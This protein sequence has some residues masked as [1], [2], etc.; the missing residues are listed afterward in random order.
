MTGELA[1]PLSVVQVTW[2]AK[3]EKKSDKRDEEK[4]AEWKRTIE[5]QNKTEKNQAQPEVIV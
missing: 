4:R 3:A 1:L 2:N 5:L